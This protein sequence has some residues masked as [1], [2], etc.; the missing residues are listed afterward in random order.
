VRRTKESSPAFDATELTIGDVARQSGL[1]PSALRYYESVGLL[2]PARRVNGQR[3]FAPNVVRILDTIRFAQEAG[4]SVEEIRTLFHG[5]GA[6]VPPPV[7]W[8]KLA[9]K[10][11]AELDAMVA[12]VERMRRALN[13][14]MQCGC[15]TIEDCRLD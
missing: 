4:F 12:R 9:N 6:D 14:A 2:Q 5:F 11:L 13:A 15:L 10:K 7:R 8:R 1:A 3:R